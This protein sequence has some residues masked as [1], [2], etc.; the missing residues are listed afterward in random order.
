MSEP[1]ENIQSNPPPPPTAEPVP[2][3]SA[4]APPAVP[5]FTDLTS[6]D[7]TMGMLCH[8]LGVVGFVGPLIIWLVKKDQSK[9]VDDQGKE[10][11]NFHLTL[12]IGHVIGAATICFTAGLINLAIQVLGIVFAIIG[13]MEANKGVA[14]RYPFAIRMI[15]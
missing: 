1:N 7:K 4:T 5:T 14:Y 12:L 2:P 8:L 3:E 15:K 6:E 11:L 10:A 9:F 13:G